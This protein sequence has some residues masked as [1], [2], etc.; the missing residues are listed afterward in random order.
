LAGC[1]PAEPASASPAAF[2]FT[3][4]GWNCK[5]H[6]QQGGGIFNRRNAEF[7]TGV[8]KVQVGDLTLILIS[9]HRRIAA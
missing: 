2:I 9:Q 5:P 1:T 3:P 4:S 8:D 7:S 6:P